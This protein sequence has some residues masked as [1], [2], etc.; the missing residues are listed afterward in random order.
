MDESRAADAAAHGRRSPRTT[1]AA[2]RRSRSSRALLA[3]PSHLPVVLAGPDADSLLA[4]AY[5]RPLV[6]VARARPR[7][8]AT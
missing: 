6:A 2:T 8:S 7:A 4:T 1:R 5:G 3:R